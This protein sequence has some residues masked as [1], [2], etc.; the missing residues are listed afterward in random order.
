MEV[1][2]KSHGMTQT[3]PVRASWVA[4]AHEEF[5]CGPRNRW[6]PGRAQRFAA[7]RRWSQGLDEGRG[8]LTSLEVVGARNQQ[9]QVWSN[10]ISSN[11]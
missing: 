2:A 7:G 8:W 9:M 11:A 6:R 3:I 1:Q 10:M 5:I 4:M